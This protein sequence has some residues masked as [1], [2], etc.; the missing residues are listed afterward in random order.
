MIYNIIAIISTLGI[1]SWMLTDYFGGMVIYLLSFCQIII[2]IVILYIFSL[3]NTIL[4]IIKKG[5]K[6]NKVKVIFHGIVL[7]S[8]I[9]TKIV[10]SEILKSERIM[11]AI[12]IDDICYYTLVLRENGKCENEIIGM[13]GF[14]LVTYGNFKLNGDT[15]VFIKNPYENNFVPD[16]LLINKKEKAIFINKEID[17]T[18]STKKKWLNYFKIQ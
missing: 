2:P 17:G 11:T 3:S 6:Q 5:I 14:H 16:S 1:L 9:L 10:Q 7:F 15:I 8:I 4:S 12:L 13:F 18:F